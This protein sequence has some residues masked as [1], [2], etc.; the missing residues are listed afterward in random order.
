MGRLLNSLYIKSFPK[1]FFLMW[2]IIND[3]EKAKA[4]KEELDV[5]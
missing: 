5:K 1:T 4:Q 3:L 2:H